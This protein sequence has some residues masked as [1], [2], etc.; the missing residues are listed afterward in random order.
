MLSF[1]NSLLFKYKFDINV[2][3][4]DELKNFFYEVNN[5]ICIPPLPESEIKRIWLDSLKNSNEKTSRIKIEMMM[6][7][8]LQITNLQLLYL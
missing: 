1:A 4:K 3:R 7:M 5:K 8:I 6:K 2:N